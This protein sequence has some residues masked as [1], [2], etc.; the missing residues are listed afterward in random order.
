MLFLDPQNGAV[1]RRVAVA[2][3][4]QVG[5]SP[6]GKF[7]V[8]NGLARKQVDIYDPGDDGP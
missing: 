2:D 7:L 4:Y 5:F 1:Q 8:V 3:P 6:D